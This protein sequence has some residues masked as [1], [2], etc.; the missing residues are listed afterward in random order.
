MTTNFITRRNK[1][2]KEIRVAFVR[3]ISPILSTSSVSSRETGALTHLYSPYHY[4]KKESYT[5]F[6][7]YVYKTITPR[8]ISLSFPSIHIRIGAINRSLIWE[9]TKIF[10]LKIGTRKCVHITLPSHIRIYKWKKILSTKKRFVRLRFHRSGI[11]NQCSSYK[12]K[13]KSQSAVPSWPIETVD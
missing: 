10:Q 13:W 3:N 1:K 12:F 2:E 5:L 6:S 4:I 11:Q 8:I 7:R 9:K